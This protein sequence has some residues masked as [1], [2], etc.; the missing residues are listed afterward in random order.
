[1]T[2]AAVNQGL[3]APRTVADYIEL[4]QS[5]Q[6]VNIY[7]TSNET[8]TGKINKVTYTITRNVDGTS[9]QYIA[10]GSTSDLD[11]LH[12]DYI[13]VTA[14]ND[15]TGL[16][17]SSDSAMPADESSYF[18]TITAVVRFTS[19]LEKTASAKLVV[20]DDG[21]PIVSSNQVIFNPINDAFTT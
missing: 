4:Y 9:V 19:G 1:M 2:I 10:G 20:S 8:Y 13:S 3:I 6:A 17:I 16:R 15:K 21:T 11:N 7:V 12:D 14:N 5:G 18:Y